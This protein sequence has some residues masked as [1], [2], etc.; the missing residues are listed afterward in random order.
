MHSLI[1]ARSKFYSFCQSSQMTNA[2]YLCMFKGLVDAVEHLNGNLGTNNAVITER[3]LSSGGDPDNNIDWSI[4]KDTI[5]EEYLAMHL[6]LHADVKQYGALIANLQK[7]D[8]V[9]GHDKQEVSQGHVQGVQYS[10]K[11]RQSSHQTLQ[12]RRSG[13][14]HVVL[15]RL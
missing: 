8:F 11:L 14:R 10:G 4:M 15:P 13:W 3:T 2:N 1:K 12:L 9:T 6:F 5:R 7:N